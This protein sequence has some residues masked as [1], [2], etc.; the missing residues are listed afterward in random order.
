ACVPNNYFRDPIMDYINERVPPNQQQ[1]V[2]SNVF[3]DLSDEQI[4]EYSAV[5]EQNN[6]AR[7]RGTDP[8]S[9]IH[10]PEC[11]AIRMQRPY[12]M[13]AVPLNPIRDS[14]EAQT[15]A[16]QIKALKHIDANIDLTPS[17]K[18]YIQRDYSRIEPIMRSVV[19]PLCNNTYTVINNLL[20]EEETLH[21]FRVG[22]KIDRDCDQLRA[23]IKIFADDPYCW[24]LDRFR[25][26][27]KGILRPEFTAWLKQRGPTAGQA[28]KIYQLVWE[29]F[30]KRELLGLELVKSGVEYENEHGN[31]GSGDN[32]SNR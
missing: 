29:F 6:E 18:A 25:V 5:N 3:S 26:A 28:N 14:K 15:F 24:S 11:D 20:P 9:L 13:T 32:A 17:R 21:R 31:A 10:D 12:Q 1:H 8:L 2:A 23:M 4:A 27:L 16:N 22:T 30:R 19:R 7:R